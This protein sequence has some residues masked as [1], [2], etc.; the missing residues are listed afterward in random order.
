MS[1]QPLA[2]NMAVM[3]GSRCCLDSWCVESESQLGG[4]SGLR[5]KGREACRG[6]WWLQRRKADRPGQFPSLCSQTEILDSKI[7]RKGMGGGGR[8]G[9]QSVMDQPQL[10]CPL[11]PALLEE[12]PGQGASKQAERARGEKA[13]KGKGGSGEEGREAKGR[14]Q[15][16]R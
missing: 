12:K 13:G 9:V 3:E 10:L 4:S 16:Q 11:F 14:E 15:E 5:A 6:G 8:A 1:P 2:D 7:C